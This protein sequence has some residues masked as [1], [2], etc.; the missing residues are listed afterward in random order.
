MIIQHLESKSF[1][2]FF[3]LDGFMSKTRKRRIY[4]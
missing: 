4:Y 1:L 3:Y 2:K